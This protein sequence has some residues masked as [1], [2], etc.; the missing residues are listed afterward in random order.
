MTSEEK[1]TS[2]WQKLDSVEDI[3]SSLRTKEINA[4]EHLAEVV[5]S[6]CSIS[7]RE[8]FNDCGNVHNIHPRWLYWYAY[9]YM[10]N[11]SLTKIAHMTNTVYGCNKTQSGISYAINKMGD[12]IQ[13]SPVWRKRWTAIKDIIKIRWKSQKEENEIVTITLSIP[14][15]IRNNVKVD[16][17]EV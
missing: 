2:D 3:L 1:I 13:T 15:S 10:T 14:K 9:R 7:V 12:M 6:M 16:I 8:M 11:E 4:A 5:A 17:K